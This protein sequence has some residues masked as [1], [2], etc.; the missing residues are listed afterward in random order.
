MALRALYRLDVPLSTT[1]QRGHHR[2]HISPLPIFPVI[3][4]RACLISDQS[5]VWVERSIHQGV[6]AAIA[7]AF[8]EPSAGRPAWQIAACNARRFANDHT[9]VLLD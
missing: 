9:A 1:T 8:P 2:P 3:Y 4:S 7:A 5:R 6:D